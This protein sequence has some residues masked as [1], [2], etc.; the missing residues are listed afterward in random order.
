MYTYILLLKALQLREVL[1]FSMNSFHLGWFLM[2]SLQFVI[3]MFVI[4]LFAS[5][6]HLFLGLP[7]DLVSAGRIQI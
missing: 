5:S 1:A 4:S 3:F 7:S 6:S 2:Q